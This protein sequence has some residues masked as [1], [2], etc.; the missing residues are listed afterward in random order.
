MSLSSIGSSVDVAVV[1][2]V[3]K[4][5]EQNNWFAVVVAAVAILR[6]RNPRNKEADQFLLSSIGSSSAI[7]VV[8]AV[9]K[10]P[11]G[12]TTWQELRPALATA[13]MIPS[14]TGSQQGTVSAVVV[15][16]ITISF[17]GEPRN[18]KTDLFCP[19]RHW[20]RPML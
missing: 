20:G 4:P 5:T 15:A 19:C 10:L 2:N 6:V 9:A 17:V 16:A 11:V 1:A 14:S 12:E 7:L 3:G 18:K 8:A 13:D